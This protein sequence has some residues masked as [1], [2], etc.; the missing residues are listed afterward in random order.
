MAAGQDDNWSQSI[1]QTHSYHADVDDLMSSSPV[2]VLKSIVGSPFYVAPE[3]LQARGYDGSKADIWS[4]GVILY[5]MLAG[6]LPFGQ[7]LSTCKRFKTFCKWVRQYSLKGTELWNNPMVEFPDWLFPSKFSTSSKGLIVSML[8]PDPQFRISVTDAM[9]HPLCMTDRITSAPPIPIIDIPSISSQLSS[10]LS[11]TITNDM[12]TLIEQRESDICEDYDKVENSIE[13]KETDDY[14][15]QS[16]VFVMEEDNDYPDNRKPDVIQE[17]QPQVAIT[18]TSSPMIESTKN[19][20]GAS[21]YSVG[22]QAYS[23][24]SSSLLSGNYSMLVVSYCYEIM[25]KMLML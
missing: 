22:N 10:N 2:R 18:A 4:L 24:N 19:I 20:F 11:P 25:L 7:E 21:S 23:S 15:D 3:I 14:A 8:H 12:E 16:G 5:A 9:R 6:N 17:I 13:E 1:P